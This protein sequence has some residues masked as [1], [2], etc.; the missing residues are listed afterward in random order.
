MYNLLFV[1]SIM[2]SAVL[3]IY[4]ILKPMLI[5]CFPL[6]MRIRL[7]ELSML[8]YI[9][10]FPL[11]KNY[12]YDILLKIT[13]VDFSMP[14]E[15]M[16]KISKPIR[17]L[18]D[19]TVVFPHLSVIF[20]TT[21]AIYAA[22]V[23]IKML[24]DYVSYTKCLKA[25]NTSCDICKDTQLNN[26]IHLITEKYGIKRKIKLMLSEHTDPMTL[27]IINPIIILQKDNSNIEQNNFIICHE[28]AHIASNDFITKL[29]LVFIK[30]IH[31]YNPFVYVLSAEMKNHLE[32]YADEKTIAGF[33]NEAIKRYGNTVIEL[34]VVRTAQNEKNFLISSFALSA[35]DKMK[36]RL[37]EMK[38][39]KIFPRSRK[40]IGAVLLAVI[41]IFNSVL[42]FA[43]KDYPV[44]EDDFTTTDE[45]F[46]TFNDAQDMFEEETAD[47]HFDGCDS[48]LIDED[49]CIIDPVNADLE[50]Q[51]GCI[52]TY[53]NVVQTKHTLNGSGGCTV[54]KYNAQY[55]TKCG[56]TIT[57]SLISET[58]YTVCPHK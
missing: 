32:C 54:K 11:A 21:A 17:I 45:Y 37:E 30:I 27:G 39:N 33:S 49:G 6:K 12:Y 29:L 15:T 53:V 47:L 57:E 26:I 16:I 5:R 9:I 50:T 22:I 40:V 43:Y 44:V 48:V 8:F 46:I 23:I 20:V 19:G 51:K 14:S 13:G 41:A 4:Y 28:L 18:S 1:M 52:H 38:R 36:V 10:P 24:T 25:L 7:L 34:S 42:V 2:G 55:C 58:T 56:H 3:L 31:W 35:K